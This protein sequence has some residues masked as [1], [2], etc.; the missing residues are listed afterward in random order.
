MFE[1]RGAS[2]TQYISD[3]VHLKKKKECKIE[4]KRRRRRRA[5]RAEKQQQNNHIIP[6]LPLCT[7][8]ETYTHIFPL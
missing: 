1:Y 8:R 3:L 6:N 4:E 7:L 2:S 5:Q